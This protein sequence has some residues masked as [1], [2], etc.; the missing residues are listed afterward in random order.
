M[1]YSLQKNKKRKRKIGK[2]HKINNN[3]SFMKLY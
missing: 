2:W 1:A 3:D